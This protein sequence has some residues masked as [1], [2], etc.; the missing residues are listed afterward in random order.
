MIKLR[1]HGISLAQHYRPHR[2]EPTTVSA[3]EPNFLL[4]PGHLLH[5]Q[6][7]RDDAAATDRVT[8]DLLHMLGLTVA[9]AHEI[10]SRPL[11]AFDTIAT[12]PHTAA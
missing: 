12:G 9:E 1:S 2:T 11:P 10:C 8:E 7:E 5:R 3:P 6:P 4:G